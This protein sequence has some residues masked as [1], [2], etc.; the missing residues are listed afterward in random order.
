MIRRLRKSWT[1][2]SM[3]L[4]NILKGLNEG[5]GT[6]GQLM[7]NRSV[8]DHADEAMDQAGQLLKARSARTPRSICRSS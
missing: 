1:I 7:Q 8:Y 2:R 3:N 5:K 4:D 6:L